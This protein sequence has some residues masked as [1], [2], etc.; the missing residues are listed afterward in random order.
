MG[1]LI[2]IGKILNFHGI[3]GEIKMGYSA[4]KESLIK[5]LKN[6]YVYINDEKVCYDVQSVRFHKNFAIIKFRQI[7]SID[8]VMLIKGLL[9]HVPEELLKANLKKDEF[10]IKDLIN[11]K[12][13]DTNGN[14][15][16]VISD[17][18]ENKA[19]NILEIQKSNGLK[20]MV[21]FVKELVPEVDL[22]NNKIIINMIEGMDI[23]AV[24]GDANEI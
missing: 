8:D 9:V 11:A 13:F 7:N 16:G 6:I 21:P 24:T 17:V 18:G 2:S 10:L 22:N 12:V 3:K 5:S 15:I 20:F 4:G 1:K 19:S 23:T 14:E